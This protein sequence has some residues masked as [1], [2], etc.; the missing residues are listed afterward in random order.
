MR[1]ADRTALVTGASRGI[2]AD[3]ARALAEAGAAVAL[4]ARTLDDVEAVAAE[5]RAE[6]HDAHAFSCDVTDPDAVDRLASDA[7]AALGR[8]DIL[9][10]NAGTSGSNPL[11]R[12][13]LEEW[14]RIMDVN[15]TGTFLCTRALLPGMLERGFGRVVNVASVA[16]LAGA[17]YISAYTAAKHAVVGFTR[18]V[19]AEVEG[20][21]T[22]VNAVCPGY[23]DTPMTDRTLARVMDKTGSDR[24]GALAMV[25]R[26]AGQT[27]LLDGA[28][29]AEAVVTLAA[30]GAGGTN[31]QAVV[32]D[33]RDPR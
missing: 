13:T 4:A 11:H 9:V 31:G 3:C 23:V 10:N 21:G 8:I 12:V 20:R 17:R 26:E 14:H 19:A 32:L 15:A 24:A 6:G 5:L 22:T 2:G 27:R 7:G 25:L 18:A 28:E 30:P 16:G 33:G 29:V 1:L